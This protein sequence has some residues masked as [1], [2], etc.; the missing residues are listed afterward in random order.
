MSVGSVIEKLQRITK[1]K[2][3]KRSECKQRQ[4]EEAKLLK[5]IKVEEELRKVEREGMLNIQP[6]VVRLLHLSSSLECAEGK[7]YNEKMQF[8]QMIIH[9]IYK[10]GAFVIKFLCKTR[11]SWHV[12]E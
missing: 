1:E 7:T 11:R 3:V 12:T 10:I 6:L 8:V 5:R 9:D 2:E 4:E